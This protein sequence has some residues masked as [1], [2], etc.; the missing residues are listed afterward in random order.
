MNEIKENLKRVL[1]K[2]EKAALKSNRDPSSIQLVA[3]SKTISPDKINEGIAA[4]IQIIG[5]NKVQEAKTK[6]A[7]INPVTWH[8]V[9]HLQTNKVKY[10]I[11]IFDMIQSVD[12]FHLAQEIDKRCQQQGIKM[13]VLIEVNTSG[14]ASKYGCHPDEAPE[15]VS[16]ISALKHLEIKGLMT[17]GLFTD[18][19]ERV[20]PCFIKLR[21]LADKINDIRS[22]RIS[23]TELSM[24]MSADYEL[25][26]EEGATLVRIGTA[27]FGPRQYHN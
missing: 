2:I 16:M 20:R 17:I 23:M 5:E 25:A 21:E 8:M 24:G 22:E 11:R 26:I 3:V 12:S 13:P 19:I 15:L 10:A 18:Q 4:G 6:K 1:E 27:I 7:E 9:G 14:E